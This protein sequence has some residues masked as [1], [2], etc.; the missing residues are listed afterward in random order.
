ME[1]R[2]EILQTRHQIGYKQGLRGKS[3]QERGHGQDRAL[4]DGAGRMGDRVHARVDLQRRLMR[5]MHAPQP[6]SVSSPGPRGPGDAPN[7]K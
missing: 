4:D 5:H 6:L 2:H 7:T 1:V 3:Q